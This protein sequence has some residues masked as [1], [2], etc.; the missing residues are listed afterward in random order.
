M[1]IKK[2]RRIGEE[3]AIKILS[4]SLPTSIQK[5]F[6]E[7]EQEQNNPFS[8]L[9]REEPNFEIRIIPRKTP[10]EIMEHQIAYSKW[11]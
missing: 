8:N 2:G 4:P 5:A 3:V 6:Y 11:R 9:P 10:L 1:R 7:E